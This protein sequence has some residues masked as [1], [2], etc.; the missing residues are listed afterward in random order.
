MWQQVL[1]FL[2]QQFDRIVSAL[3]PGRNL[4]AIGQHLASSLPSDWGA[5]GAIDSARSALGSFLTYISF[6][7][8]FINLSVVFG[9]LALIALAEGAMLPV[10]VWRF[11][12]SFV[13]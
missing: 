1:T 5:N 6:L 9:V 8:Y 11:V 10:R 4:L 2:Q 13:T 7:D 3:S 12:R